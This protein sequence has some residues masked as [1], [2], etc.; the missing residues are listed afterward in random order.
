MLCVRF[1]AQEGMRHDG[2][3]IHDWMFELAKSVG[4]KGGS[5]FRAS[6]GFGRHGLHEDTFFELA[7]KLPENIEFFG[8]DA[9]IRQLIDKVGAAGL[10]LV[11]VTHPVDVGTTG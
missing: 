9:A 4:I 2:K 11:Y 8:E 1:F 7:G 6:A 10:K 5:S 3:P